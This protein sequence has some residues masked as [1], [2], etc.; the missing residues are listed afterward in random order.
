M[1]RPKPFARA[2]GQVI[3]GAALA[4]SSP[5][6]RRVV[7]AA[8]AYKLAEPYAAWARRTRE[9]RWERFRSF[10]ERLLEH[11]P[12][13]GTAEDVAERQSAE[14]F[15][16][17]ELY[18]R[19]WLMEQGRIEGLE[20]L[21]AARAQGRGVAAVFPHFG[22]PYALFTTLGV[23]GIEAWAVAGALHFQD[24]GNGYRGR[25]ARQGQ[26]YFNYLGPD[27]VITTG[28]AF[29]QALAVLGKGGVL[30]VAFDL[31]GSTPTPFLGRRLSLASGASR[32][33]HK[34]QAMVTPVT[35]R[36]VGHRP[37]VR[38]APAIDAREHDDAV[39][40]QAA[41]AKVIEQW[42]LEMPEAVWPLEHNG[43]PLIQGSDL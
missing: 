5:R 37:V 20:H 10:Q 33:P 31:V 16:T 8:A 41:V 9:P 30:A 35:V 2:V 43:T 7:P 42:A 6:S 26:A 4:H 14:M 27:H 34:A 3:Q 13:A 19:P 12:L 36:R 39:S 15:R 22:I 38:F 25:F 11:T 40:L 21:N 23:S 32:L 24:L 18:W 28:N 17:I 1:A 29:E